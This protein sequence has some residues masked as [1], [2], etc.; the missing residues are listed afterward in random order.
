MATSPPATTDS[1]IDT[2]S[3]TEKGLTA[4]IPSHFL[5][6]FQECPWQHTPYIV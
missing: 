5:C 6:P 2:K 3:E 1:T 4:T